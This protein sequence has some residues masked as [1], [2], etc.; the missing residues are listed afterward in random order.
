MKN[1]V[2]LSILVLIASI[3]L[4]SILNADDKLPIRFAIIGDRTGSHTPGVYGQCIDEI[5]RLKP[6]FVITVG[7]MI[8]GYRDDPDRMD[9]EWDEY[10]SIVEQ[11]TMELYFTPGNHDIW[12][13]MSVEQYRARYGE[14]NY[15]FDHKALH[16]AVLDNSRYDGVEDFT[17][18]QLKWLSDDLEKSD[19]Q[20]KMVFMHQPFWFWTISEGNDDPV[21]SICV[22][23]G[24]DAVFT[25]HFHKYFCGEYDNIIYTSLGS[26]GGGVDPGTIGNDYHFAW[27]TL[28]ANGIH[29]API[30]MG[31]V[32]AWDFVTVDESKFVNVIKYS[33]ITVGKS[34]S[35]GNDLTISDPGFSLTVTNIH[36]TMPIV[37]SVSWILSEG[38]TVE[39]MSAVAEL[40]PG[41]SQSFDFTLVN[42]GDVFP[43]P[44]FHVTYPYAAEKTYT[45]KNELQIERTAICNRIPGNIAI[46][47][48]LSEYS[49]MTPESNF[50]APGGGMPITDPVEFYFA[51]DEE[52]LY[53][54][55]RCTESVADSIVAKATEQDAA[56]YGEDC[57]GYFIQPD[58]TK[59]VSYQIYFS[60]LGTVFDQ[61]IWITDDG[62]PDSEMDW[63]GEYEVATDIKD[64]EWTFE[65]RIP[66][67]QWEVKPE[68]GSKM[69]VNFRRK[70]ARLSTACD[71]I[72]PIEYDPRL[73]GKIELR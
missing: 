68:A 40:A 26:S 28:D 8:E 66:L 45:Y 19:A 47:G 44:K 25:G 2:I 36:E 53:L 62:Y 61:H 65:A 70:Q 29:I 37:D 23:K 55:A 13:D 71:W 3:A 22:E 14:P 1:A 21:H 11:L 64:G 58:I 34:L 24:V 38:W 31:A 17:P 32:H 50:F 56:V 67:A 4:T 33:G 59:D 30:D 9:S 63:N 42:S 48:N 43:L 72:T 6:E 16:I 73:Y 10:D 49:E 41:E 46:D 51:W 60:P 35:I 52:N 54:A 39:P 18:E 57:V 27:V 5:E 15:S 7:D 12:S 20:Y 69:G